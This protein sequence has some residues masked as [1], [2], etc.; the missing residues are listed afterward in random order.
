VSALAGSAGVQHIGGMTFDPALF[1]FERRCA[2]LGL[3]VERQPLPE[4]IVRQVSAS[5][6]LHVRFQWWLASTW[7]DGLLLYTVR[8][9]A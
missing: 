8:R 1:R 9:S 6:P 3:A 5:Q 7:D 4:E 2:R